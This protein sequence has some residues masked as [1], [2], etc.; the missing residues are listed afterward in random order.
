MGP[1]K[2][3]AEYMLIAIPRCAAGNI[4]EIVP[5][6]FPKGDEPKNPARKRRMIKVQMFWEPVVPALKAVN[7]KKVTMKM[8]RRPNVSLNGAKSNGPNAK[9]RTKSEMP[10]IMI[11][12]ST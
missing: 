9:P 11:S 6:E 10:R 7:R 8:F 5:P 12:L 4:S 1:R 3:A 2:G